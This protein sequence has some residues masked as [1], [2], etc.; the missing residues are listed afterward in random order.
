MQ[1][2]FADATDKVLI[3]VGTVM[4]SVHGAVLPLMC[5]VFGDMT[6][7][8]IKDSMVSHINITNPSEFS[9]TGMGTHS[10]LTNN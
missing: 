2:R 6:D 7:S 1:F 10:Y 8:F 4:A 5:I 3:L 9:V